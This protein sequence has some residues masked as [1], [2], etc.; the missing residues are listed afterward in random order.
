MKPLTL[1]SPLARRALA[2]L[3]GIGLLGS[4][5]FAATKPPKN[6]SPCCCPPGMAGGPSCCCK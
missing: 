4:F 5:A 2:L 3:A 1:A 6:A